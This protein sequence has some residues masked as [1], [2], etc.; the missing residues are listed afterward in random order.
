MIPH[1]FASKFLASSS[2][3][4]GV[5][6]EVIA[7]LENLGPSF[8]WGVD[9]VG[10]HSRFTIVFRSNCDD[11]VR[12]IHF[13]DKERKGGK[14]KEREALEGGQNAMIRERNRGERNQSIIFK[15]VKQGGRKGRVWGSK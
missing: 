15:K 11:H 4:L 3:I 9:W 13:N 5:L 14:R 10:I 7:I 2:T 8:V 1:L 6:S 12:Q